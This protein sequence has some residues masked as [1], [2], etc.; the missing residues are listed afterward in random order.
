MTKSENA[1]VD[2]VV[3]T[4]IDSGTLI[5]HS[6]FLEMTASCYLEGNVICMEESVGFGVGCEDYRI[7][8]ELSTQVG[9]VQREIIMLTNFGIDFRMTNNIHY[10]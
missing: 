3:S 5:Q 8:N 6:L 7:L 4:S 10:E 9:C 2:T 1:D